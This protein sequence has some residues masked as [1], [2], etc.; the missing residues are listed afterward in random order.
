MVSLPR[1][2]S[3]RPEAGRA[4]PAPDHDE[5]SAEHTL[6]HAVVFAHLDGAA[7]S[8]AP[9]VES[10]GGVVTVTDGAANILTVQGDANTLR[11]ARES[12]MAPW[13]CWSERATGTNPGNLSALRETRA[14]HRAVDE[15]V[16]LRLI[17]GRD[18]G[19]VVR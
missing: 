7:A 3:R 15:L 5:Q 4:P 2:I 12:N 1:A 19:L 10:L 16:G 8:I 18:D 14:L 11:R 6:E 13:S 9:E 17:A